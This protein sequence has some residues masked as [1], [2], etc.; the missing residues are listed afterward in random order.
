MVSGLYSYRLRQ[1]LECLSENTNQVKGV[2]FSNTCGAN[3]ST[4]SSASSTVSMFNG[5][6]YHIQAVK[7]RFHL[8]SLG[9][10]NVVI[11]EANPSPMATN[12]TIAQMKADDEEKLKKYKVITSLHSGLTDHVFTKTINLET[13]KQV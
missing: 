11:F 3:M 12:P 2:I 1:S 10:W 5:E 13:P 7:M 9:L 4:S 6:H 8:R